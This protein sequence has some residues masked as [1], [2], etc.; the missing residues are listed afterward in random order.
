MNNFIFQNPTKLIFGKGQ[1]ANLSKFIPSQTKIMLT[2]GGGSIFKN[3]IYDQVKSALKGYDIIEFSGIEPN[4]EY[5]TLMRAVEIARDN[6]VDM[7]LAVGGGSVIDGTKF[8]AAA[9]KYDGDPWEFLLDESKVSGAIPLASVLTLP[10]TG[11]EMNR[12]AVVSRREIDEKRAFH[13][14]YCFPVFSIL[15]PE[16][17]YSLPKKQITNGI[18]DTYIHTVEQYLT[19]V[20]QN[21]VMDRW[22][23]SLLITLVE[24]APRLMS[25]EPS[26]DDMA[27]FVLTATMA[28]NGFISMGAVQD[29]ATH[30]IGHELTALHELDHG[31]TLAVVYPGVLSVMR[32]SKRE[33]LLQYGKRVWGVDSV[34]EAIEKTEAFFRSV[35][36]KTKLSEYEIGEETISKIV[37]RMRSR[38]WNLGEGQLVTP[39]KVDEILHAVK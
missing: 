38:G 26:Y 7:L 11:S 24:L 19:V 8:I 32:E 21:M 36:M 16:A 37:E 1:I 18:V 22:A 13:S 30:L 12:A 14:D 4:P 17:C 31:Q 34:D 5:D 9:L 29:W 2:Y 3:G 39:E 25:D 10:A 6:G 35:G 33:K 15:D 28:L 23:E 27:N 20:N